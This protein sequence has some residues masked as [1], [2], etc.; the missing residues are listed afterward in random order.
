MYYPMSVRRHTPRPCSSLSG[1]PIVHM[2]I[3]AGDHEH[4]DETLPAVIGPD[5]EIH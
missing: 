5:G 2:Q 1:N 3:D 4:V